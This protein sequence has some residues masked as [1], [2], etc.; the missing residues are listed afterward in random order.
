MSYY[1]TVDE[2]RVAAAKTTQS[3]LWFSPETMR[4][5]DTRVGHSVY[6]GRY[7]VT[8][9]KGPDGVRKWSIREC[10]DG[11]IDTV[12]EFQAYESHEQAVAEIQR[13]LAQ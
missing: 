2:V 5:F 13:L 4:F 12:G 7:F 10:V 8:S 11:V 9:E 1:Q 6:G 3:R